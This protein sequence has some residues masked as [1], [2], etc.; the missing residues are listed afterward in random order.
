[1]LR[2]RLSD[3]RAVAKGTEGGRRLLRHLRSGGQVAMLV[4]QKQNDGI[5]VSF[6]GAAVMTA[7]APARLGLRFGCPILPVRLERL[8]GARFRFTVLPAFEAVDTGDAAADVLV[9]MTR[10]NAMLELWVRARP[11]QWLWLHRRWPD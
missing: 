2:R 3:R 8:A 11:E 10:V 7:P 1:M 6:F 5:P 4:D 9:T